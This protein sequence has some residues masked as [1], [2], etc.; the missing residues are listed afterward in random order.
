MARPKIG[1]ER[2]KAMVCA[3]RKTGGDQIQSH[4]QSRL[5]AV[6]LQREKLA[7]KPAARG[8]CLMGKR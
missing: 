4:W 5:A 7:R 2:Y 3:A 1:A 8:A 6:M